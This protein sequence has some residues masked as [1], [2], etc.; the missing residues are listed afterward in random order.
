MK[1]AE[2][3]KYGVE[4]GYAKLFLVKHWTQLDMK[5]KGG[6]NINSKHSDILKCFDAI[7][8][9]SESILISRESSFW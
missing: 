3:Q 7:G 4:Y 9:A 8:G 1:I 2:V 6:S 5:R